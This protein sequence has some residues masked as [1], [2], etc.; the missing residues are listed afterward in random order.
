MVFST[1]NMISIS[2]AAL[3]GAFALV[4]F[5]FSLKTRSEMFKDEL[6]PKIKI[7]NQRF[8]AHK[9]IEL[10]KVHFKLSNMSSNIF[11]YT[12]VLLKVQND[13]QDKYYRIGSIEYLT[14]EI[15]KNLYILQDE[16]FVSFEIIMK[17]ENDRY[18]LKK[19]GQWDNEAE[20]FQMVTL[21][22]ERK[23]RLLLWGDSKNKIDKRIEK[24]IKIDNQKLWEK[25]D[26]NWELVRE[27]DRNLQYKISNPKV[28]Q[29]LI[30]EINKYKKHLE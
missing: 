19:Y 6:M 12:V 25:V 13:G 10:R 22:K 3:S 17:D 23:R 1:D 4:S 11:P 28:Y 5:G 18:Y 24:A 7:S 27:M 2:A 30:N 21:F 9:D 20:R 29:H 8:G 14:G 26:E 15:E 16:T